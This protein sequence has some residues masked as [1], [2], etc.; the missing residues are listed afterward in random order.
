MLQRKK[1]I[2]GVTKQL[3]N[4]EIRKATTTRTRLLN[5][6]RKDRSN[7]NRNAYKR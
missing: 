3:M 4:K 2:L 5:K 1:G 7:E 6:F